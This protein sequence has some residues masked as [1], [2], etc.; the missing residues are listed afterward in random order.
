MT[1]PSVAADHFAEADF[2]VGSV[3][4][5]SASI[6][7]R[8]LLTFFVVALIANLPA[9]LLP[10]Q[11][12]T[13]PMVLDETLNV[14]V[15]LLFSYVVTT[16]LS[17][18]AEAVILHAAFQD[19]RRQPVRLAESL[20]A[21]LRRFL[22]IVGLAV[23]VAVL[24]L[25]GLTLFVIPGLILYTMWFVGLPACV[26]ERRGPWTSLRRSRELTKGHRWKVFA[27]ALLSIVASFGG[28]PIGSGLGAIAGPIV[29]LI[30]VVTWTAIWIAF[31]AVVVA[32]TYHDLRVAKEGTDIDQVAAVFD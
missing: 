15:W 30:G 25:L 19:M 2:R 26:V 16:V 24:L 9:L 28:L 21:V 29:A 27:L 1:H 5:R 12:P 18:L 7:L 17:T 3:I 10:N 14:L 23:V 13:E 11:Q 8:H 22:T 32:V 20:N 31:T 4:S 6:L